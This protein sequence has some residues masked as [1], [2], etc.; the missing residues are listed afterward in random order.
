M[1]AKYDS[2]F[3]VNGAFEDFKQKQEYKSKFRKSVVEPFS[4]SS[5][6]LKRKSHKGNKENIFRSQDKLCSMTF[7]DLKCK[8][9]KAGAPVLFKSYINSQS[10]QSPNLSVRDEYCE[11]EI[12]EFEMR[13]SDHQDITSN[14]KSI[15]KD[16][17]NG[18]KNGFS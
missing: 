2:K 12:E 17:M 18:F 11:T 8:S 14:A 15:F 6:K 5:I 10:V 7:Q 9:L 1:L 4:H 16:K 13:L 3:D